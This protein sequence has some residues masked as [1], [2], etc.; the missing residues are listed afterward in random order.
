MRQHLPYNIL[1]ISAV[2]LTGLMVFYNL[3]LR[4]TFAVTV[5]YKMPGIPQPKPVLP[6][7]ETASPDEEDAGEDDWQYYDSKAFDEEQ[8]LTSVTFPLDINRATEDELRFIPQVGNVM[9]QRIVQYRD[10]IGAYTSLD[11]LKEIKGVGDASF[12][13]ISAYLI[14]ADEEENFSGGTEE[15]SSGGAKENDE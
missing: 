8:R 5:A 12:I 7:S 10:V 6:I 14:I 15:D 9:A 4:D 3:A 11:Q 1:L 2:A 13:K